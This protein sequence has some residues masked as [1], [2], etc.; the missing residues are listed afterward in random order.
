VLDNADTVDATI[1]HTLIP[2]LEVGIRAPGTGESVRMERH[3]SDW[4][5]VDLLGKLPAFA[6]GFVAPPGIVVVVHGD[7]GS[8]P[9]PPAVLVMWVGAAVP[10]F[11][12]EYDFYYPA[13]LA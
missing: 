6:G 5:V 4:V 8:V 13:N 10:S 1:R 3:G 11:A 9:R 2:Y 7:D 12:I